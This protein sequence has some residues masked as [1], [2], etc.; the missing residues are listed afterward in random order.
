MTHSKEKRGVRNAGAGSPWR[1]GQIYSNRRVCCM[2]P[3]ASCSHPPNLSGN[4]RGMGWGELAARCHDTMTLQ[5]AERPSSQRPRLSCRQGGGRAGGAQALGPIKGHVALQS[6]NL[7]CR[8]CSLTT[9]CELLPTRG[10]TT[11]GAACS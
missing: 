8:W 2:S 7:I 9:Q 6:A 11:S 10:S 3:V 5:G 1:F 4:Q